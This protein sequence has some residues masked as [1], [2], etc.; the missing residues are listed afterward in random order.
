[1]LAQVTDK[2]VV[3]GFTLFNFHSL[4]AG[5]VPVLSVSPSPKNFDISCNLVGNGKA[6]SRVGNEEGRTVV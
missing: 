4:E 1:M 2:E 5:P 3:D 6:G